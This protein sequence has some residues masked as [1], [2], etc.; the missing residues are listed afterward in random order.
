M[1]VD[2]SVGKIIAIVLVS[3]F[4]LLGIVALFLLARAFWKKIR[5]LDAA[6]KKLSFTTVLCAFVVLL[7]WIFNMGWIR[8]AL[9]FIP[10]PFAHTIAF[11]A[12]N[13][14]AAKKISDCPK[15]KNNIIFS[16]IFYVLTYLLLPDGGDTGGMYMFFGLIKNDAVTSVAMYLSAA[17]AAASIAFLC[18]ELVALRT[19]KNNQNT[20]S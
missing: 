18:L 7:S 6:A 10:L 15:L 17:A 2:F 13:V 9:I 11:L 14:K 3:I 5:D 8:F 19:L 1:T 4:N 12:L 20:S 16:C